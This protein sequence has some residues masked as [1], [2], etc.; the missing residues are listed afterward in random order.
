MWRGMGSQLLCKLVNGANVVVK[1]A[2][3]ALH[4]ALVANI[5][6]KCPTSLQLPKVDGS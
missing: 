2:N 5:S 1:A 3:H 4:V 6:P